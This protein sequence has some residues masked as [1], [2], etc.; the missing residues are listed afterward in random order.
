M[1]PVKQDETNMTDIRVLL[2]DDHPIVR[3][4][5]RNLLTTAI[6]I[7]LIGETGSGQEALN[8]AAKLAPDVM[9]LDM[10]LNDIKGME[11]AH[12]L[13]EADS[14]V[15]ILALSS[16][17]DSEYI[18]AMLSLGANGYLIKEEA[19]QYIVEAIRGVA[20]GEKG[21]VSRRVAAKLGQILQGE[22]KPG[23]GLTDRE[24]QVLRLVVDGKTN[25]E[26]AFSLGISEKTVEKHLDSIFTKLNVSSRV[27]AAVM[28]VRQN[29]V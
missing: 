6:G 18:S 20:R 24:F 19:P 23:Y 28:A 22:N 26:V 17:D 1:H 10:E 21:W 3:E 29:L 13:V 9:I 2:V 25:G 15:R 4:G 7:E 8:M 27:E 12:R 16:Y 11:V 14:K 5:I